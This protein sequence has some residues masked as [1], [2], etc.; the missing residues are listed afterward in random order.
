MASEFRFDEILRV[1]KQQDVEFVVVGGIAAILHGA[2]LTTQD[3]D[4]VYSVSAE[5]IS[6]LDRALTELKA[7]YLDPAGRHIEP[8]VQRLASMKIH[9]LRTCFGRLD[10]LRAIGDGLTFDRLVNTSKILD[11]YGHD[12]R[13][14]DLA[15]IIESKE[16]AGRPKDK[17]QLMFLRQLIDELDFS[18]QP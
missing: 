10:L 3:L 5:N 9:L 14:L 1:L 18:D 16:H 7:Y 6:R 17:Y 2:P 8:S 13:V 4:V 15:V 11:V 12:V